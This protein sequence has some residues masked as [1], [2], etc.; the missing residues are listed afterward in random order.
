MTGQKESIRILL[1]IQL[2]Q[3]ENTTNV[4]QHIF[5]LGEGFQLVVNY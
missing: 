1:H 2:Q 4:A 5:I 3:S